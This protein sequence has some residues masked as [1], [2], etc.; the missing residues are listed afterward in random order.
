MGFWRRLFRAKFSPETAHDQ[1]DSFHR[2][3]RDGDLEEVKSLI[4]ENQN[5]ILRRDRWGATALHH[6]AAKGSKDVVELLLAT[7]ADVN[8]TS[9][10]GST[11]LHDAAA[12]GHKDV[13][14]L[15]LARGAD[16]NA[17][18]SSGDTPLYCAATKDVA[19]LLL[20]TGAEVNAASNNGGTPLHNAAARGHQ[21]VAELLLARGADVNA[22]SSSGDT[23][24]HETLTSWGPYKD[25]AEL[26][27]AHNADVNAKNCAGKAPLHLAITREFPGKMAKKKEYRDMATLLL[28]HG[29]DVKEK[30]G[31]GETPLHLA[32]MNRDKEITELLVANKAD[33]NARN[34]RN[35]TPLHLATGSYLDQFAV[36]LLLVHMA[37]VDVRNNQ[38]E[39]PLHSAALAHGGTMIESLLARKSNVDARSNGG[40]TPL[41]VAA[42]CGSEYAAELLIAK[43]ADVNAKDNQGE[44]PLHRCTEKRLVG[45]LIANKADVNTKNSKG[46]TP[47]HAAVQKKKKEIAELILASNADID[48]ETN[49][50]ETPLHLAVR[51]N[52]KGMVE[53]LLAKG[54]QVDAKNSRLETPLHLAVRID[55]RDISVLLLANGADANSKDLCDETPL[56][57]AHS[58]SDEA[59]AHLRRHGA[60]DVAYEICTAAYAGDLQK[61]TAMLNDDANLVA[62]RDMIGGWTPLI[63]AAEGGHQ[64]VVQLLLANKADVDAAAHGTTA[65]FWAVIGGYRDVVELLL[66]NK[67][68]LRWPDHDHG[69][70]EKLLKLIENKPH[71]VR[72]IVEPLLADLQNLDPMVW[73]DAMKALSMTKDAR[74]IGPLVVFLERHSTDARSALWS[75]QLPEVVVAVVPTVRHAN[76]RLRELA[77][78]VLGGYTENPQ[79]LSELFSALT[80]ADSDVRCAAA[81]QLSWAIWRDCPLVD[82]SKIAEVSLSCYQSAEDGREKDKM[83]QLIEAI[84]AKSIT[85]IET[86]VLREIEKSQDTTVRFVEVFD[87]GRWDDEAR[88]KRLDFTESREAARVELARR[89][90]PSQP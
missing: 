45:L 76:A 73:A 62:A 31:E 80:D 61:V 66:T 51:Q 5:V 56:S 34:L 55:Y 3:A 72:P 84:T 26:L 40:A 87:I 65:L 54:A 68:S 63:R 9:N 37:D 13:A 22:R 33:V 6:A 78:G 46:E 64:E 21:E 17:R 28:A 50:G 67:A 58:K 4:R 10:D 23:P 1:P 43:N 29:A 19:E 14:E 36:E 52:D 27:L 90:L 39:I 69:C 35:E 44:T 15:L 74:A 41:H 47:L 18:R 86:K 71:L 60:R 38:G 24:L 2:K 11:P 85:R 70:R 75:L 49:E 57:V 25:V 30:D 89:H 16:V 32:L 77:V 8:A 53:L 42:S 82:A 12:R 81:K 88:D 83:A 79:A 59:L 48:A 7:G 20:T